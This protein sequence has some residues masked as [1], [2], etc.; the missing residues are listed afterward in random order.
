MNFTEIMNNKNED[1]INKIVNLMQADNS[2]DAPADS[3]E[4]SKNLFRT[5]RVNEPK[6]SLVQK[7]IAVLQMDLSPGRAAFGERSASDS[8]VRQLLFEAGDNSLDLRI[9][10]INKGF[11]IAGQILGEGFN[12]AEVK[13]FNENKEFTAQSNELSEFKFENISKGKYNLSLTSKE[14]EII[15]DSIEIS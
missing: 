3:I 13:I 2:A 12:E 5:R 6:K 4:W 14:K 8:A 1:L 10:K 11:K 9:T 15:I 7:V